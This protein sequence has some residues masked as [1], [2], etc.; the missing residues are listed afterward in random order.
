M[1]VECI[2]GKWHDITPTGLALVV[3]CYQ[4]LSLL[5][6]NRNGPTPMCMA[7][8]FSDESLVEMFRRRYPGNLVGINT[9]GKS[10]RPE[11]GIEEI[12]T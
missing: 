4:N 7:E 2:C 1:K 6:M 10:G 12:P 5:T 9:G 3:F 8:A 11:T